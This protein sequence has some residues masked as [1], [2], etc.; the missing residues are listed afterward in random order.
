M[1][2]VFFLLN[3]SIGRK[4]ER[5]GNVMLSFLIDSV[6]DGGNGVSWY[7]GGDEYEPAKK[8]IKSPVI[9]LNGLN[10]FVPVS[11]FSGF[12]NVSSIKIIVLQDSVKFH[13]SGGDAAGGYSAVV[14]GKV[15]DSRLNIFLK[16][17]WSGEFPEEVWEETKYSSF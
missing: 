15:T 5:C 10:A 3:N 14:T 4:T 9:R 13:I 7:W 6:F 2:R 12:G 11:A 1:I 8:V 17:V 16:K